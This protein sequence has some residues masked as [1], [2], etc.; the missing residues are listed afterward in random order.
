M[1]KISLSGSG[2]GPGSGTAPGYSTH[3]TCITNGNSQ[4]YHSSD[5]LRCVTESGF[6]VVED[7]DR[8]GLYHTLLKYRKA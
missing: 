5:L 6:K 4:M 1:V 7:H 3:P 8:V 2:E